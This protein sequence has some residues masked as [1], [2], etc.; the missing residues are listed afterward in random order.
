[1]GLWGKLV[2]ALAALCFLAL[3]GLLLFIWST[4]PTWHGLRPHGV[5]QDLT[6]FSLSDLV[7]SSEHPPVR[8]VLVRDAWY[9]RAGG[10]GWVLFEGEALHDTALVFAVSGG[11]DTAL[12]RI[13]K[14]APT[15]CNASG[16]PEKAVIAY[17]PERQGAGF[18]GRSTC[19]R[20]QMD[21]RA[22]M[23]GGTAVEHLSHKGMEHR[24]VQHLLARP[25]VLP[26]KI[27]VLDNARAFRRV[28]KMPIF[29]SDTPTGALALETAVRAE[30]RAASWPPGID[31][32]TRLHDAQPEHAEPDD[33]APYTLK[34]GE[35]RYQLS[36]EDIT[37]HRLEVTFTCALEAETLCG[38]VFPPR[39]ALE[40]VRAAR[41]ARFLEGLK[42]RATAG[43]EDDAE[44]WDTQLAEDRMI[45]F[46]LREATYD[47]EWFERR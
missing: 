18:T 14:P 12:G 38:E 25:D 15:A 7:A 23:E 10:T 37:L 39:A 47:V 11:L 1:M 29:A 36:R 35:A 40:H 44:I 31:W 41:G 9:E 13:F 42:A 16:T 8:A 21:V 3:T 19:R 24:A 22:L 17:E 6:R 4:D 33:A 32:A 30:M 27:P 45:D 26:Y 28:I 2:L 34:F 46:L 43:T 20:A 5:K